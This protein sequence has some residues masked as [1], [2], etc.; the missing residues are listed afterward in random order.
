MRN[1]TITASVVFLLLTTG[2]LRTRPTPPIPNGDYTKQMLADVTD[3]DLLKNYNAMPQASDDD[4]AKKVERRNQILNELIWLIDRHYYSFEN[5]FYGTQAAY[6]VGG[7]F[8]SLGLTGVSSVAG[9]AHLKSILSAIA[10]GTT[11]LKTSIDKNFLDQ[12]TRSAIVQKMRALRATQLATIQDENHMKAAVADYS[13]EAGIT[14]VYA[15]YD[16]GTVV[17]ALQGIAETAGQEKQAAQ[18]K[19]QENSKKLQLK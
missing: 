17:A 4:K 9:S 8:V 6:N 3:K 2:C 5:I 7:D 11:G 19:Q 1:A 14:N 13:L 15:Y 18:K 12:Q 16:A 10:T